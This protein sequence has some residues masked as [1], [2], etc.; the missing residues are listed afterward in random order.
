MI[1]LCYH[2]VTNQKSRGI[3]NFSGKHLRKDIFLEQMK[4]I[5]K[6]CK[7]LDIHSIYFHLK[8]KIPFEKKSVA[9]S[10]DDGFENNFSEALPILKKLKIPAIF[11]ICPLSIEKKQMF[12]VDKIE[13]LI[14][15]SNKEFF[16]LKN[17]N[18]NF[19]INNDERK[20]KV[21]LKIKNI[22]KKSS[23]KKKDDIIDELI[24]KIG[25]KN[26]FKLTGNYKIAS[27]SQIRD[28][29][30]CNLFDIGGHSLEHN[31]LTKVKKKDLYQEI[32]GC[33]ELIKKR[34]GIRVMHFSYPEGKFNFNV[35]NT[36][37]KFK[38]L[39][40]PMATGYQNNKNTNVFKI[41]RI[42]VG[43]NKT[44]FPKF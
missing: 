28:A 27:W 1:F 17:L 13:T 33:V 35:I 6:K 36:L 41:K 22:C 44:K 24:K 21:V 19:Y 7:I 37:R 18:K 9:I 42:M 34:T 15:N 32:K 38:I 23:V 8:N 5:K 4:I 26:S 40:C 39:T 11:Y 29:A 14:L 12:W 16:Y 25:K 2:G 43:F 3:E 10:F 20:K 31:I 30:R